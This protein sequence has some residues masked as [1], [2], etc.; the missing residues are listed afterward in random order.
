MTFA[1][2]GF[3]VN[4]S[5]EISV[6]TVQMLSFIY[7]PEQ[8]W[9]KNILIIFCFQSDILW[10]IWVSVIVLGQKLMF[11]LWPKMWHLMNIIHSFFPLLKAHAEY[12]CVYIVRV[13]ATRAPVAQ[14]KPHVDH[15]AVT[16]FCFSQESCTEAAIR[17]VYCTGQGNTLLIAAPAQNNIQPPSGPSHLRS[18]V[19]P[20]SSPGKPPAF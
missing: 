17:V 16:W 14:N 10:F 2:K 9:S 18:A 12:R 19:L 11:K 13:M 4:K 20:A 1:W 5:R 3:V 15:A 8:F 7:L 6:I